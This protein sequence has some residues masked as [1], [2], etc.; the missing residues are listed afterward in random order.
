MVGH[1]RSAMSIALLPARFGIAAMCRAV[2][3][4]GR[5][6]RPGMTLAGDKSRRKGPMISSNAIFQSLFEP[7]VFLYFDDMTPI[8][9]EMFDRQ[10]GRFNALEG[11]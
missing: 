8:A 7:S 9:G 3:S 11:L 1:F 6:R 5:L 10:L 2:E 4:A